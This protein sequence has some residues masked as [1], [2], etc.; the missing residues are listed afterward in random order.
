MRTETEAAIV[1]SCVRTV[2]A[3]D[4]GVRSP[5]GTESMGVSPRPDLF[6]QFH[7]LNT[8]SFQL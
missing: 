6:E 4:L 7:T 5:S 1:L 8:L 3:R 2:Q